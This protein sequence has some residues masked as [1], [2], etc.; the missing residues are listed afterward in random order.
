VVKESDVYIFIVRRMKMEEVLGNNYLSL[1]NDCEHLCVIG[2]K[3]GMSSMTS[4][5]L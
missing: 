5:R 4:T 3:T 2:M 1:K